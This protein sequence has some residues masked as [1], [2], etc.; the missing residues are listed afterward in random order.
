MSNETKNIAKAIDTMNSG[1]SNLFMRIKC[2]QMTIFIEKDLDVVINDE[3][4]INVLQ[5]LEGHFKRVKFSPDLI[6]LDA[7]LKIYKSKTNFKVVADLI[8][9]QSTIIS[10]MSKSDAIDYLVDELLTRLTMNFYGPDYLN[11]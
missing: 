2:L 10:S 9:E 3:M 5:G 1:V 6:A 4:A 7:M 11:K 8:D